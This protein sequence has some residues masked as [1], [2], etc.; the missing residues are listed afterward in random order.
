MALQVEDFGDPTNNVA[1]AVFRSEI[2][3]VHEA[4]YEAMDLLNAPSHVIKSRII[5]LFGDTDTTKKRPAQ[6]LL[7]GFD[8]KRQKVTETRARF[9]HVQGGN[10]KISRGSQQI[11]RTW[12]D[13]HSRGIRNWSPESRPMWDRSQQ[14]S[15]IRPPQMFPQ[16]PGTISHHIGQQNFDVGAH[17]SLLDPYPRYNA[18]FQPMSDSQNRSR[19]NRW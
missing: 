17:R 16:N 11:Q 4:L 5:S 14:V 1:R 6:E 2:D 13:E 7:S 8:G 3:R 15:Y 9:Q 18:V 12:N 10:G 19:R